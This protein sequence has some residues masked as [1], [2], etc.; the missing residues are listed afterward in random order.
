MGRLAQS[1]GQK[2]RKM[3]RKSV[4]NIHLGRLHYFVI[5][6]TVRGDQLFKGD[7][8]HLRPFLRSSVCL[9]RVF[10]RLEERL[11]AVALKLEAF[12]L[13]LPRLLCI[14][15]LRHPALVR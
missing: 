10:A 2:R 14:D 15:V 13:P 12:S 11:G 8:A 4:Y 6:W 5:N 1:T 3:S 7:S 9:L